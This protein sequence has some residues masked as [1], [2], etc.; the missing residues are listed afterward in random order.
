MPSSF[1]FF[2]AYDHDVDDE[3]NSLELAV[4]LRYL[5]VLLDLL[6]LW[7]KWVDRLDQAT[8]SNVHIKNAALETKTSF[9][10]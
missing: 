5:F 9:Q 2:N 8:S 4:C 7:I 1:D 6:C 3:N 10:A